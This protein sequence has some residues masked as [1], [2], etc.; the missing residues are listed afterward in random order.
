[1]SR[2]Q[3]YFI[4]L[5]SV[6]LYDSMCLSLINRYLIHFCCLLAA[7]AYYAQPGLSRRTSTNRVRSRGFNLWASPGVLGLYTHVFTPD[8]W[9]GKTVRNQSTF[10]NNHDSR[11]ETLRHAAGVHKIDCEHRQVVAPVETQS[12][13]ALS[14]STRIT[15]KLGSSTR[16][17]LDVIGSFE[18]RQPHRFGDHDETSQLSRVKLGF[19][20]SVHELKLL[21]CESIVPCSVSKPNRQA[22]IVNW[23]CVCALVTPDLITGARVIALHAACK[24][25]NQVVK[26]PDVQ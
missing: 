23:T 16:L 2:L 21:F 25:N 15:P 24:L 7:L 11:V 5:K 9:E 20:E 10:E 6:A 26:L 12:S 1:M 14:D 8:R 3:H 22:N 19:G 18:L 17:D 4:F 13:D